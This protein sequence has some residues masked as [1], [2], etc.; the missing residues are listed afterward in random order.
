LARQAL[1]NGL[2][3]L[4]ASKSRDKRCHAVMDEVQA[5]V[6]EALSDA[7]RLVT[8]RQSGH[9]ARVQEAEGALEDCRATR[10]EAASAEKDATADIEEKS[11]AL[12]E[13]RVSAKRARHEYNL[14]QDAHQPVEKEHTQLCNFRDRIMSLRDDTLKTLVE[15][16]WDEDDADEQENAVD[17]LMEFAQESNNGV[18]P[19]L[20]SAMPM[21]LRTQPDSRKPFDVRTVEALNKLLTE[22]L[23]ASEEKVVQS[24]PAAK[25]ASYEVLGEWAIADVARESEQ[26]ASEALKQAKIAQRT[27]ARSASSA[28]TLVEKQQ[29]AL[30]STVAEI[31][32]LDE[33]AHRSAESLQAFERMITA[34][35]PEQLEAAREATPTDDAHDAP[36]DCEF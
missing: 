12:E 2:P 34:E 16:E 9:A 27:A 17:V 29:K 10:E 35:Q 15:G 8:E 33:Q 25:E 19:A 36:V 24:T 7:S 13:A 26:A 28:A 14:S 32:F 5:L 23:E 30:A 3:F 4:V 21:A 20:R 11:S 18:E 31:T 22:T 1:I 6:R